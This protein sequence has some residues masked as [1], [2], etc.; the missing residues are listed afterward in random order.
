MGAM[1][2]KPHVPFPG[3]GTSKSTSG[4]STS[5]HSVMSRDDIACPKKQAAGLQNMIW[6]SDGLL[7]ILVTWCYLSFKALDCFRFI[8]IL[9]QDSISKIPHVRRSAKNGR[10]ANAGLARVFSDLITQ[11]RHRAH[12]PQHVVHRPSWPP[13]NKLYGRC[14]IIYEV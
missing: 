5:R 8:Q 1:A 9:F 13:A 6:P 12:C 4:E 3:G 10:H 11:G 7:Q 14:E 2:W